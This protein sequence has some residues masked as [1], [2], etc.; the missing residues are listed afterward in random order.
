MKQKKTVNVEHIDRIVALNTGDTAG[1]TLVTMHSLAERTHEITGFEPDRTYASLGLGDSEDILRTYHERHEILDLASSLSSRAG[2]TIGTKLDPAEREE[3]MADRYIKLQQVISEF[4]SAPAEVRYVVATDLNK[5]IEAM[6]REQ[7]SVV[8]YELT[9][10]DNAFIDNVSNIQYLSN[11]AGGELMRAFEQYNEMSPESQQ[12]V[13]PTLQ[14]TYHSYVSFNIYETNRDDVISTYQSLTKKFDHDITFSTKHL[15][16]VTLSEDEQKTRDMIH[17]V[18]GHDITYYKLSKIVATYGDL[19]EGSR[20]ALYHD[21]RELIGDY[22]EAHPRS[23]NAK[24]LYESI[25][26]SQMEIATNSHTEAILADVAR[27]ETV[28]IASRESNIELAESILNKYD[29]L[30]ENDKA[31][32]RGLVLESIEGF[33]SFELTK[34][35][36]P[37]AYD[38]PEITTE[39]PSS[40]AVEDFQASLSR[41]GKFN[42]AKMVDAFARFNDLDP[43]QR[44]LAAPAMSVA[45][46]QFAEAHPKLAASD[47][48]QNAHHQAMDNSEAYRSAAQFRIDCADLDSALDFRNSIV[49]AKNIDD[50]ERVT[51]RFQGLTP[52]VQSWLADTYERKVEGFYNHGVSENEIYYGG[53]VFDGEN[54]EKLN[55]RVDGFVGPNC[56]VGHVPGRDEQILVL[57]NNPIDIGVTRDNRDVYATLSGVPMLDA[58]KALEENAVFKFSNGQFVMDI[59][60]AID[61]DMENYQPASVNVRQQY[62]VLNVAPNGL[63]SLITVRDMENDNVFE[64]STKIK[65][66]DIVRQASADVTIEGDKIYI[67][68][69]KAVEPAHIQDDLARHADDAEYRR[70]SEL[71][72]TT[73]PKWFVPKAD[74]ASF[75]MQDKNLTMTMNGE[76][77]AVQS[78]VVRDDARTL[79]GYTVGDE[80]KHVIVDQSVSRIAQEAFNRDADITLTQPAGIAI[81]QYGGEACLRYTHDDEK[82]FGAI[83]GIS[84]LDGKASFKVIDEDKN[85]V[86]VNT[87]MAYREAMADFEQ[88][89]QRSRYV[90]NYEAATCNFEKAE[91]GRILATM[92]S[93]VDQNGRTIEGVHG[94]VLNLTDDTV[95]IRD[96]N[97]GV[98][99][100]KV[101]EG[102][103]ERL[104]AADGLTIRRDSSELTI[105]NGT[106]H[107]DLLDPNYSKNNSFGVQVIDADKDEFLKRTFSVEHLGSDLYTSQQTEDGVVHGKILYMNAEHNPSEVEI[108]LT[109][110]EQVGNKI[111]AYQVEGLTYDEFRSV[112]EGTKLHEAN[113]DMD[114]YNSLK[115]LNVGAYDASDIDRVVKA[116]NATQSDIVSIDS[117]KHQMEP[118]DLSRVEIIERDGNYLLRGRDYEGRSVTLADAFVRHENNERIAYGGGASGME[119]YRV[120]G[121]AFGQYSGFDKLNEKAFDWGAIIENQEN[122]IFNNVNVEYTV[123]PHLNNGGNNMRALFEEKVGM[124]CETTSF[125]KI[126]A[127]NIRLNTGADADNANQTFIASQYGVLIQNTEKGPQFTYFNPSSESTIH[128]VTTTAQY[129]ERDSIPKTPKEAAERNFKLVDY[130]HGLAVTEN[131]SHYKMRANDLDSL[132]GDSKPVTYNPNPEINH[133]NIAVL[134]ADNKYLPQEMIPTTPQEAADK[135]FVLIDYDQGVAIREGG[136]CYKIKQSDIADIFGESRPQNYYA[137]SIAEK[138]PSIERYAQFVSAEQFAGKTGDIQPS[139]N[140]WSINVGADGKPKLSFTESSASI[141]TS[142]IGA[143]YDIKSITVDKNGTGIYAELV[144]PLRHSENTS[145]TIHQ[146]RLCMPSDKQFDV[147][148]RATAHTVGDAGEK[149]RHYFEQVNEVAYG[150]SRNVQ[151]R[152]NELEAGKYVVVQNTPDE[153]GVLYKVV[154]AKKDLLIVGGTDDSVAHPAVLRSEALEGKTVTQLN[155]LPQHVES[156]LRFEKTICYAEVGRSTGGNVES[157]IIGERVHMPD[158]DGNSKVRVEGNTF[159]CEGVEL[160]NEKA[161]EREGE[162]SFDV[163]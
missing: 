84:D 5:A 24:E 105:G 44:E 40:E 25:H 72:T 92:S 64:L 80:T 38:A 161:V 55:L 137:Q 154:G 113:L 4:E 155:K 104:A 45:F 34:V 32:V 22:L 117:V 57:T 118:G 140:N 125:H 138:L 53:F 89:F 69:S 123:V 1:S 111:T 43:D 122:R 59:P 14:A 101:D 149:M 70:I 100:I 162:P 18:D 78:L 19:P 50:L 120:V 102:L 16:T 87:D 128:Q 163:G 96:D 12:A 2:L 48:V 94:H 135:K 93:A 95:M 46:N 153:P 54:S 156:Q 41:A 107:V 103:T 23:Q 47:A 71:V 88:Q 49:H 62:E 9:A 29:L 6:N 110:V 63:G 66:Q 21:Y 75:N 116:F 126:S 159:R 28:T 129:L 131:G 82:K 42:S 119:R 65:P 77:F 139:V 115:G 79:V 147:M 17:D 158:K 143:S 98:I 124:S 13:L 151:T 3:T 145:S 56:F 8:K 141:G 61:N 36:K 15:S 142:T 51:G 11:T 27:L 83:V 74:E 121:C 160:N 114:T 91:D 52:E 39:T 144:E 7:E 127:D 97:R 76:T 60:R 90:H 26:A 20:S 73:G 99:S 148:E 85:I 130:E 136:L 30:P 10:A 58:N 33:N 109:V 86:T 157:V 150:H 108:N 146:V 31:A 152:T 68:S 67:S 133:F 35:S 81:M 132:F 37:L 112:L 134:S 106:G